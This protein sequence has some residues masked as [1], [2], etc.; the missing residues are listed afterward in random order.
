MKTA[1][2]R[3]EWES[4]DAEPICAIGFGSDDEITEEERRRL[5]LS[6]ADALIERYSK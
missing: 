1:L 2:I 6:L 3:V 4:Y 5:L